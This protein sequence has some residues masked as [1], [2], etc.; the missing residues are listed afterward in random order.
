MRSGHGRGHAIGHGLSGATAPGKHVNLATSPGCFLG[1][2]G[3]RAA[4]RG[5]GS[6]A[7]LPLGM[8]SQHGESG[9]PRDAA[10]EHAMVG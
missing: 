3:G 6:C 5:S 7:A 9:A 2:R 4:G 1:R 8:R 10:F